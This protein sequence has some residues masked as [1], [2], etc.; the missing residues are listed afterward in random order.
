MYQRRWG[1]GLQ[2]MHSFNVAMLSK[3]AWRNQNNLEEL[4]VRFLKGLNFPNYDF[5]EASKGSHSSRLWNSILEGMEILKLGSVWQIG[6][7]GRVRV[8]GDPW[9]LTIKDNK[10]HP[11]DPGKCDRDLRVCSLIN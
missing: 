3:M 5:L 10:L 11:V 6:D 4:W 9:V 7:G 1:N 2:D 8:W